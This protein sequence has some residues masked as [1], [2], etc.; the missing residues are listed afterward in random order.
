[1]YRIC[2]LVLNYVFRVSQLSVN[3]SSVSFDI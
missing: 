3:Y 2:L 1:M